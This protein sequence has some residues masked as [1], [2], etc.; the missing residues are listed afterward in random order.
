MQLSLS[1]DTTIDGVVKRI[2]LCGHKNATFPIVE[3]MEKVA[4]K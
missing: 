2:I 4:L 1:R 3:S